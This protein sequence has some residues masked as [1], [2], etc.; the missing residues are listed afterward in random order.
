MSVDLDLAV[1]QDVRCGS[2]FAERRIGSVLLMPR[3]LIVVKHDLYKHHLHGIQ[4]TTVDNI[5][6]K[7]ANLDACP[8]VSVGATLHR[9]KPRIS[10]TVRVV[11]KVLKNKILLGGK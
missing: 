8:E 11:P 1:F 10:L 2:S 9:T 6:D 5:D 7:F 3:S 4:E